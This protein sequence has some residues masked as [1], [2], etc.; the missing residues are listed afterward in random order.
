MCSL[1][2]NSFSL[3]LQKLRHDV[4]LKFENLNISLY[5]IY[6]PPDPSSADQFLSPACVVWSNSPHLCPRA[7]ETVGSVLVLAVITPVVGPALSPHMA[8]MAN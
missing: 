4:I 6:N 5:Y 2:L 8:D 1:E 3:E 7:T